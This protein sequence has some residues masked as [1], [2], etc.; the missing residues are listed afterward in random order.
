MSTG[1]A[2]QPLHRIIDLLTAYHGALGR[3]HQD[4][5]REAPLESLNEWRDCHDAVWEGSP[6]RN[7]TIRRLADPAKAR[8][9]QLNGRYVKA[10]D[11]DLVEQCAFLLSEF[12]VSPLPMAM[13]GVYSK[14][15]DTEHELWQRWKGQG[16]GYMALGDLIARLR[17]LA[18]RAGEAW[19]PPAPHAPGGERR[20]GRKP[21]PDIDPRKD[22]RLCA[23]WAAARGLGVTRKAFCR[24]RGITVANLIGAQDREKYRRT[25]DAE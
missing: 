7:E 22:K 9:S 3:V 12:A 21:D 25:R 20:R 23:D 15:D 17:E 6:S 1:P 2:R 24:E 8:L 14:R 13:P 10:E 5:T 11:F 19:T 18:A 4:G 16:E